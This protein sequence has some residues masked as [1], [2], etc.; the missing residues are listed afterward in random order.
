MLLLTN[1]KGKI[2]FRWSFVKQCTC[3][4]ARMPEGQSYTHTCV[5]A[6]GLD[7]QPCNKLWWTAQQTLYQVIGQLERYPWPAIVMSCDPNL[8]KS[9]L[10]SLS[11]G[12]SSFLSINT[13]TIITSLLKIWQMN[14]KIIASGL[15]LFTMMI[16]L[17]QMIVHMW[18]NEIMWM[19][20]KQAYN[21][22]CLQLVL[23]N[24][25][26][27]EDWLSTYRQL[28]MPQLSRVHH[29]SYLYAAE[30]CISVSWINVLPTNLRTQN[31]FSPLQCMCF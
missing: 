9:G 8:K 13:L 22:A 6:V 14:L 29:S 21:H 2:Q 19:E 23:F 15:K 26:F 10:P 30:G 18:S 16:Q 20:V 11:L 17:L 31:Q 3:H 25:R 7:M 24:K 28:T 1:D 27:L 12:L 5:C 4:T